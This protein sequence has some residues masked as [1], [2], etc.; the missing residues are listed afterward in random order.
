LRC[1]WRGHRKEDFKTHSIKHHDSDP[2]VGP[3]H[4]YDPKM[5][6]DHIK[7]GTPVEA[8]AEYALGL[9]TIKAYELG[10]MKEWD[11]LEYSSHNFHSQVSEIVL[12]R[13]CR[14]DF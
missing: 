13:A 10:L 3:C 11:C 14:P 6:L 9:V 5:I 1:S 8:A 4:I 12:F 2:G 7:E